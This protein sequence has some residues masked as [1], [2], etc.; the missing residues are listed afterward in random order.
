MAKLMAL[1]QCLDFLKQD[2][3]QNIII[4][5]DSELII[6][7]VKR[8]CCGT[9]PKKVSSHWRLIQVFQRIQFHLLDLHT[10][11]FTHVRRT[12]N[13]VVNIL[14][15]QGVVCT[16]NMV[17]LIW[18]EMPQNILREQC[19]NQAKEDNRVLQNRATEAGSS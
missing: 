11:S 15:N 5:A 1:E 8:I 4:E 6:N 17:K 19:F 10:V 13:K 12:A 14:A 3:L 2:N 16:K 7:S 18:R 9:E